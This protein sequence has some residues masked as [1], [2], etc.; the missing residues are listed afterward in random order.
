MR[1]RLAV[2]LLSAAAAASI[3]AACSNQGEG[4]VCDRRAGNNGNDDCQ[5]GLVC[6]TTL[7]PARCCPPDRST[8][9]T[10]ACALGTPGIGDASS[11]P[12]DGAPPMSDAAGDAPADAGAPGDA[13]ADAPADASAPADSGATT[14]ASDAGGP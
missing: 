2:L 7:V 10:P 11:A 9:T 3:V 1:F 8:A 12:P 6:V 13:S 4:E 5:S 14:D